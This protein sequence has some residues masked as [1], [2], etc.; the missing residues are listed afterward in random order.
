M[1]AFV[2]FIVA[3][4][5][6]KKNWHLVMCYCS[7][8]IY[9][10]SRHTQSGAQGRQTKGKYKKGAGQERFGHDGDNARSLKLI[11]SKGGLQYPCRVLHIDRPFLDSCL[12]LMQRPVSGGSQQARCKLRY[13]VV[14]P[15]WHRL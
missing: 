6:R 2:S 12:A 3:I 7:F 11:Q 8:P 15:V 10:R 13:S 1:S 5:G 14:P 9:S 4:K